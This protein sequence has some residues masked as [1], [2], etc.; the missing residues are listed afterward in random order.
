MNWFMAQGTCVAE[1]C[2][3]WPEWERMY[4]ILWKLDAPRKRNDGGGGG[5]VGEVPSQR[6]KEG[7]RVKNSGSGDQE[8]GQLW[9]VNR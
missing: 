5:K 9:K 3:V 2:L 8:L 7:N 1:D 4:F 6:W